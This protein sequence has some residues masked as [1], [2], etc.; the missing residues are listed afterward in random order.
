MGGLPELLESWSF[1]PIGAVVVLVAYIVNRFAPQSRKL[2]RRTLAL[3]GVFVLLYGIAVLLTK[4]G[5]TT[6]GPRFQIGADLF[7]AFTMVALAGFVV[8]DFLLPRM[9]VDLV[10][11]TSD[12]ILGIAYVVTTIGVAHE[13]GMDPASVLGASALVSAVVALSLQA[14]LGNILGGVALQLDGSIHVGDAIT[15]E[16]GRSGQVK[17]IR[18]R[19]TVLET[20]EWDT[21]IVPNASLLAQNIT[22]LGKRENEPLQRRVSVFFHVDF[23]F[24]PQ[25]VMRVVEEAITATPIPD[26]AAS[27]K[28]SVVCVDLARPGGDSFAYYSARYWLTDLGA[29][30][31]TASQVRARIHAALRRNAIPLARPAQTVF[32]TTE[33]NAVE[34]TARARSRRLDAVRAME[35]FHGL[36]EE[37]QSAVADR[38]HFT[39]YAA[40]ETITRQGNTAHWLYL[41]TQGRVEIRTHA[42]GVSH[43]VATVDGPDFFGEMA[44]MTGEMRTA[45]IVAVTD[46]ECYRLDRGAFE[47]I[48]QKRP[49]VAEG[50]S[51]TMARRRVALGASREGLDHA[52]KREREAREQQRILSKIRDFFGLSE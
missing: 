11:I 40:G 44:L 45:D 13:A 39:P 4:A 36:T 12:I 28:P 17:E 24:P 20:K 33:D 29:D 2:M 51:Q 31:S 35:L 16:N 6:W 19:H 8:F 37:E 1:V 38:L 15:L 7:E 25:R 50:M 43:A 32:L 49:E 10:S 9:K 46:V 21:I 22:I 26:V 41:V 34:K 14:T 18:W 48:L 52:T 47:D 30:E 27:P 5:F 23:R 42:D 3:Y